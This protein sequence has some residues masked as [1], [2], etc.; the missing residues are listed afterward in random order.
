MKTR[1]QNH[2]HTKIKLCWYINVDDDD[3]NDDAD[4]K[5]DG[6]HNDIDNRD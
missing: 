5:D 2:L 6:N 3:D 4:D 1:H